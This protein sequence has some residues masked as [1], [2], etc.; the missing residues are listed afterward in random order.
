[1]ITAF[2]SET[3]RELHG[4]REV[5]I[6]TTR[7][8]GSERRTIIWVVVDEDEVFVRSH[9]G[10]RGHW[11]QAALDRPGEVALL[12][13]DQR[14]PVTAVP[15]TD[16]ASIARCSAGLEAKYGHSM[17]L[18]SMLEPHTLGTTLRLQP[19]PTQGTT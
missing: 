18:R 11:F 5:C 4:R 17:S 12:I 2:S 9:R 19:R 15:A 7:P 3:L 16:E 13:D 1:M 6:V 8:D 14:V 10:D